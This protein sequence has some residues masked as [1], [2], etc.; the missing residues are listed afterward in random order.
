MGINCKFI[1]KFSTARLY[2]WCAACIFTFFITNTAYC[3]SENPKPPTGFTTMPAGNDTTLRAKDRPNLSTANDTLKADSLRSKLLVADSLKKRDSLANV[4]DSAKKQGLEQTLGIKIS[5]D[6]LPAIV[7]ATAE[8][9]AVLDMGRNVFYLYKKA[10]VNYEDMQLN[11]GE[12]RYNQATN[13]VSANPYEADVK[14][15]GQKQTFSQGK[16]KF[17]YDSIQYNFKSK[18]AIVRNVHSQYGEGFVH[19][20]QIK[21]NP[22]QTFYGARST[23]TTCA[24]DTPHFGI[25][26]SK[27]KVIPGKLI[28]SGPATM[29]IEGVPTPLVLPFGIFPVT[30]KQK[31]GFVLPTYTVEQARGLG[32][33]NGGYYYYINDYMDLLTQANLYTKGSYAVSALS[34][35]RYLYHYS[36]TFRF[37]YAYN[38][39]GEDFEPGSSVTKDFR[40]NW[41]HQSDGKAVPGQTFNASVDAGTSTFYSNNSYDPNQILQNQYQSNITYAK[42]WQGKPFG[43]TISALHNQNTVNKQINLTL[44]A[45]NFHVTQLNPFQ[46]KTE[47]GSHWWDKIT[48][49]YTVDMLNKTT[50]YDSTL[51]VRSFD[52]NNFESGIHHSIPISA[53]YTI[54]RYVNMSFSINYNEY[55]Y[56]ERLY[57]QYDTIGDKIDSTFNR[58]FYSARDFNA[59]VNFSTRIYGM[60]LFKKGK[61]RGIRHVLTPSTGITYH[62][63]F[64]ASPFNYY[65]RAHL[66]TPFLPTNYSYLS[67]FATSIIGL[68]PNGKAA[69]VNFGVNNNLQIKVRSAKDTISGFKN[70]TLIDGLGANI[71]Y[72]P[73]ADS[74]QWS[75]VGVN[76]RTNVLDK[77]NISSTATYDPYAEDYNTGR[78]LPV[79]ME[80]Q[81]LGLARF[82]GATVSLGSNFHS[83]P[84]GGAKNPTNSEEYGRVIRNAGYNEYVDFNIPWSF[85][86]NYSLSLAKQYSAV[87]KSDTAIVSQSVTFQG[88]LQVTKRW[89]LNITSGYN[90]DIRQLTLTSIDVYRDLHCWAMHFQTVPFGPRKSYNFTIN[91][92]SAILQDLKLV[93]R[94]DYRDAPY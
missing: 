46:K 54:F 57:Q 61:L 31:S 11:A 1:S 30:D 92:K 15:T 77:I 7:T 41:S 40:V 45:I 69:S 9:S 8:D 74:F 59:G 24:L 18:R 23:Y 4:S 68:P 33:L 39:T 82:T 36:G 64:G 22:D 2:A 87:S 37:S 94:R 17:S 47:V 49:S 60:K 63:D 19:S 66:D 29:Y 44:P 28:I 72:N 27:I 65:Y 76:F 26:A 34:D 20:E 13:I 42:N 32:L 90:F 62:P 91:V 53:S 71:A 73:A 93:R 86:V 3:Q 88:E 79:L 84:L 6:A 25:V 10:Q 35:Y 21:R 70:V 67:P 38:K 56:K 16:E 12:V 78:R 75:T 48:T 85:N 80:N 83:K 14:D 55:W 50:F 58:G 89:K 81:G 43:L 51:S 5:K 52:L